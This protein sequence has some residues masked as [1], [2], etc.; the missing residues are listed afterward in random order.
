MEEQHK[1]FS[2]F[3]SEKLRER[4][5]PLKKLAELTRIPEKHL[6]NLAAG[7]FEDLPA[8]PYLR[9][10]LIKI[11]EVLGFEGNEQWEKLRDEGE[12]MGSGAY[13]TLPKNRFAR[14]PVGKIAAAAVI[15]IALAGYFGLRFSNIL[16]KPA[17][18]IDAPREETITIGTGR[19]AVSGSV[20]NASRVFINGEEATLGPEGR[21]EKEVLLEQGLNTIEITA[22]KFLG[23]EA[24]ET[25]QI[26]YNPV[27]ATST[28]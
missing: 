25:Y 26:F 4:N 27:A 13:D 12:L 23:R 1:E 5:V 6:E 14:R 10:Y 19:I 9:G 17:L 7:R 28:F 18:T 3:F 20:K 15:L 22:K 24:K 16:G 8:A 11:G 2:E 21:F